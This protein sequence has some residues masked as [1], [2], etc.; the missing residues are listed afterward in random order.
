[1]RKSY[2]NKI[3]IQRVMRTRAW[4]RHQEKKKKSKMQKKFDF[5]NW[6]PMNDDEFKRLIGIQ[7]HSPKMCSCWMCGN[8]RKYFNEMTIQEKRN[9]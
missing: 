8:P 5:E 9:C 3:N 2:E 7:A 6:A 4:R 1:V